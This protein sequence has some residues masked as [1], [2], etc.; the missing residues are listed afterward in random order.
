MKRTYALI[1]TININLS[2]IMLSFRSSVVHHY[3]HDA[4]TPT[5]IAITSILKMK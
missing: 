2:I 3:D 5:H 1:K 4:H